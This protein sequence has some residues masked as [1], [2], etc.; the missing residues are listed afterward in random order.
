V[1]D[2]GRTAVLE[3]AA[4]V[5]TKDRQDAYGN[6]EDSFALIATLWSGWLDMRIT[7]YDVAMMM[8]LLKVARARSNPKHLD[9]LVDLAG[10]A[11]LAAEMVERPV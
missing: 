4:H 3:A 7:P 11:A 2:N 10:Y 8:S 9:N 5:I 6:A 1:N